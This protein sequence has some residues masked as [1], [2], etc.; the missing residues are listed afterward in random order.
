MGTI[1]LKVATRFKSAWYYA[2]ADYKLD[3]ALN[4]LIVVDFESMFWD[5]VNIRIWD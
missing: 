1:E 2:V 4:R 5:S 3:S